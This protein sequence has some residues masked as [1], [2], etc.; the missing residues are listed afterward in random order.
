MDGYEDRHET[1]RSLVDDQDL[2]KVDRSG[3]RGQHSAHMRSG[4]Y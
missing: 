1:D 3:G 2:G 4:I